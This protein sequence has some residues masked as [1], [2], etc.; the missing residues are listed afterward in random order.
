MQPPE[1]VAVAHRGFRCFRLA[2]GAI[3][4]A[5]SDRVDR[6]VDRFDAIDARFEQF[7]GRDRLD[8]D[9]AAKFCCSECDQRQSHGF[10]LS[11]CV[12]L[13][14]PVH[15]KCALTLKCGGRQR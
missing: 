14:V 7:D 1:H 2:A 4:S 12:V 6:G 8:A 13:L 10:V 3:E 15:T 5:G 11:F 9:Q